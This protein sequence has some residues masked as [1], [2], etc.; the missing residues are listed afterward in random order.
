MLIESPVAL[1]L[2]IHASASH[3][4]ARQLNLVELGRPHLDY[5]LDWLNKRA[6]GLSF[7]LAAL[8]GVLL[9]APISHR[10]I[11]LPTAG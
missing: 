7:V 2:L 10:Q 6:H 8:V 3:V 5:R 11:W 9:L 4:V 1:L